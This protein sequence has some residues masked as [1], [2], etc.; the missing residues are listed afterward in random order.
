MFI[1]FEGTDGSGKS[2]ALKS[3]VDFLKKKNISFLLT[4][5]PGCPYSKESLKI[6][7]IITSID[8]KMPP[9]T[10]ALL[11][12]ADRKMH[13]DNVIFPAIKDGKIVLCD[14]YIDS[15]LAYQG[16]GR[17]LGIDK[18]RIINEMATDKTYP[19]LTI[20]FDIKPNDSARRVNSR[21]QKDRLELAG[22]RFNQKVYDGYKEIIKMYPKR[23]QIVDASKSRE[24]VFG[25]VKDIVMKYIENN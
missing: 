21:G 11:F 19:D 4:R 15:S 9:M 22:N 2:T 16:A 13:L 14:R 18:V 24:E 6:R 20:F 5:E 10:E 23:I 8:S 7:E 3:L 12:A 25:Q 1:T 17:E